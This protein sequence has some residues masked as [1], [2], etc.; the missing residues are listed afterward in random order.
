MYSKH[1]GA[2][3]SANVKH[4]TFPLS[5]VG[6][7]LGGWGGAQS[8]RN[9]ISSQSSVLNLSEPEWPNSRVLAAKHQGASRLSQGFMTVIV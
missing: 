1:T 7:Y 5:T 2:A 8:V 6:F 3:A 4:V 9:C